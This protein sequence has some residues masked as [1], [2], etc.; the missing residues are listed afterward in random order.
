MAE[1]DGGPTPEPAGGAYEPP[2]LVVLGKVADLTR[3]IGPSQTDATD[4]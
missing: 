2:R 4:G 1:L 3:L